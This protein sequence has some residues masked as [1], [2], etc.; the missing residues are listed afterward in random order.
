MRD[1]ALDWFSSLDEEVTTLMAESLDEWKVQ[2][3][4]R[5]HSNASEALSKADRLEHSFKDESVLDVREYITRK[6]GLYVEAGEK[7]QDLI[8]RRLH[9]KLD[10]TLAAAVTLRPYNNTMNDFTSKVYSAEHK[11]RAQFRQIQDQFDEQNREF[12]KILSKQSNSTPS[13]PSWGPTRY[14]QP[15]APRQ[16]LAPSTQFAIPTVALQSEGTNDTTKGSGETNTT[17]APVARRIGTGQPPSYGSQ[18]RHVIAAPPVPPTQQFRAYQYSSQPPNRQP[19]HQNTQNQYPRRNNWDGRNKWD[20]PQANAVATLMVD[21]T[22][23]EQ[24]YT[25]VDQET[26]DS[27][28]HQT[29]FPV[30]YQHYPTDLPETA[31]EDFQ[32]ET[33]PSTSLTSPVQGNES[34]GR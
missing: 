16:Q 9:D 6:Y 27:Y 12:K 15:W 3:I 20:K 10:A 4:R 25:I 7:D 24:E 22:F 2:L 14:Q 5:F 21:T 32:C 13:A 31:T 23:G 33:I 8:V 17:S 26:F 34:G 11:A 30:E 18:P 29:C 1:R 28:Q 19:Y